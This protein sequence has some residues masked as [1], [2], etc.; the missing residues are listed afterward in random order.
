M[1]R[2]SLPVRVFYAALCFWLVGL[3]CVGLLVVSTGLT[4]HSTLAYTL[5]IKTW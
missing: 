3:Q 2:L 5:C 4:G 1:K